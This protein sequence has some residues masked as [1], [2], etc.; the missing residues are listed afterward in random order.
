MAAPY[1]FQDPPPER[2]QPYAAFPAQGRRPA[3]RAFQAMIVIVPDIQKGH[4]GP[5]G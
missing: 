1:Q 4:A 2:R 5:A 3:E